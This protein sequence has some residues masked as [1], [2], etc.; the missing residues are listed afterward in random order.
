MAITERL[1]T[2][3]EV[4]D[5][6]AIARF[7]T[8]LE[9]RVG[10]GFTDDVFLWAAAQARGDSVAVIKWR[11]R[12]EGLS[13]TDY[14]QTLV[15]ITLHSAA[16]SLPL[17]DARW[18]TTILQREAT[19]APER[20]GAALS[21]LAS[22][23]AEGRLDIGDASFGAIYG[24]QWVGTLMQI[25][26][27]EPAYRPPAIA[28]LAQEAAG[29]YRLVLSYP[30]HSCGGR[31]SRIASERSVG[32]RAVIPPERWPR[33]AAFTHSPRATRRRLARMIGS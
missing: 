28:S 9:S 24:P 31:P 13:R 19:T 11:D 25:A 20:V 3:L 17:M 15:R 2:A 4:H 8:L 18:A 30:A 5:R 16:L 29:G 22:G 26:L 23:F 12:K 27:I 14:M 21:N 32:S 33:C 7:S 6:N 1:F 10:A